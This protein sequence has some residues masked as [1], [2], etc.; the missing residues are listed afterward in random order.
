MHY[1]TPGG[2][3]LR[4]V[5]VSFTVV[6]T[7][8][9]LALAFGPGAAS[10]SAENVST[11]TT[12]DGSGEYNLTNDITNSNAGTC[13]NVTASDVVIDGQGHT[14]G[15]INE[16][17]SVGIRLSGSEGARVTNVT[18]RNVVLADWA[19]GI[20]TTYADDVTVSGV[21]VSGA[22]ATGIALAPVGGTVDVRRTT[23]RDGVTDREGLD[24]VFVR[25]RVRDL[26]F[27][28]LTVDDAGYEGLDVGFRSAFN[29]DIVDGNV[30]VRDA[31]FRET[32][33]TAV[34]I[35]VGGN[36]SVTDTDFV[37]TGTEPF[38][39]PAMEVTSLRSIA[40][41]DITV[42]GGDTYEGGITASAF[43]NDPDV[44]TTT[45]VSDVSMDRVLAGGFGIGPDVL[46]AGGDDRA[47]IRNV[48]V[49]N[50]A[51]GVIAQTQAG[52]PGLA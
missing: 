20:N 40:I 9:V 1:E 5:A 50:G 39:N 13:L 37:S 17:D 44:D 22:E 3:S 6:A 34:E 19:N 42:R 30:T 15:G 25:G 49:T 35:N 48:T 51:G 24:A 16:T 2:R 41:H 47:T 52:P 23:V 11:C 18:I 14:V 31:S 26:A 28:N 10:A 8:L 32:G 12:I 7:V 4:R 27:T 21:T 36:L 38:S 46:S 29:I 43:N 45:T 33:R